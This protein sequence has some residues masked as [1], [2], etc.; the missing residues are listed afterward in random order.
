[1]NHPHLESQRLDHIAQHSLYA[2]GINS[3]TIE[4]SYRILS[5]FVQGDGLLEVGPAEGVMTELLAGLGRRLT[6]VEGA[7]LFCERLKERFPQIQVVHSLF[8]D[9]KTEDRFDT[10]ILSQILEHVEDPVAM[11]QKAAG[12]LTPAGKIFAAVPNSR[13]VHRQAAVLLKLLPAE[14]ALNEMDRHHGHRRV[15]NPET[16]RRAFTEAG[17]I[18]HHTGGYWLKPLANSQIEQSWSRELIE[19]F[20]QLGERF[21]EIAGMIYIIA[22]PAA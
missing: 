16:F 4:Y 12:L 9:Y 22:G 15:F 6:V 2:A 14:D 1:M 8:E 19:A 17:L 21:P 18:V 20:M 5:R 7:G 10:I 11:L 3:L 13:S